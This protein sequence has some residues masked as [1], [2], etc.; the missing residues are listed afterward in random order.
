[1]L[2]IC[3]QMLRTPLEILNQD[4]WRIGPRN[5]HSP[6]LPPPDSTGYLDTATVGNYS[7][8]SKFPR[9]G[10]NVVLPGYVERQ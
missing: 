6:T 7:N 3:I 4:F 10:L 5:M 2:H 1:M 9:T 8:K